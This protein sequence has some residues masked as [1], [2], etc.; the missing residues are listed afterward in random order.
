MRLFSSQPSPLRAV[1]PA[2]LASV[3][4]LLAALP[5]RAQQRP[6]RFYLPSTAI[7]LAPPSFSG[8]LLS[9]IPTTFE[10]PC[11]YGGRGALIFSLVT[12][13]AGMTIDATSGVL[14]WIP[15][16]TAEGTA[17]AVTVGA[18]DG[19][20]SA[21]VSFMVPVAASTA[22]A[23]SV[24]GS[25]VKVTGA[26][27]LQNLK[28]TLPTGASVAPTALGVSRVPAAAAPGL[29]KGV[30]R[31]SEFFRTTPVQAA[32]G[33][34]T[35]A[36]PAA[37]VPSGR[38]PEE[39]RLYLYSDGATNRTGRHWMA[40]WH[41]LN[42]RASGE[43]TIDIAQLGE[44]SF[45]GVEK[46]PPDWSAASEFGLQP[47]VSAIRQS[48]LA[49]DISCAPKYFEN[50][51]TDP[52]QRVCTVTGD[53]ALTVIVKHFKTDWWTPSTDLTELVGW[54]GAAA[55]EFTALGLRFDSTFEVA[56]ERMEEADD[57]GFVSPVEDYKV[58]H[59]T[60]ARL[61]KTLLQGT[62]VHE[63]FHHAQARTT[64]AGE[65]NV[66]SQC[67]KHAWWL[68]EGTARWFEDHLFDD[69]DT[70]RLK[71]DQPLQP[72]LEAGLG[73]YPG[74]DD[75]RPYARF[76]FC[77]MLT[78]RCTGFKLAE[79]LNKEAAEACD[80]LAT[81]ERRMASTS[82][83]CDFYAGF[84]E[85]NTATLASA[86]LLY[87]AATTKEDDITLLDADEQAFSFSTTSDTW[88][89]VVVPSP[90][91]A[92][93]ST[94]A[95]PLGGY[96]PRASASTWLVRAA[97]PLQ[98]GEEAVVWFDSGGKDAWVWIA[99]NESF[100]DLDEGDWLR[101]SERSE[102]IYASGGWAPELFLIAV[103]PST[104]TPFFLK[105][106]AGVRKAAVELPFGYFGEYKDPVC[107]S[108]GDFAMTASG[109]VRGPE[110]TTVAVEAILPRLPKVKIVAPR[111]GDPIVITGMADAF[112]ASS[113]GSTVNPDGTRVEWRY[114]DKVYILDNGTTTESPAFTYTIPADAFDAGRLFAVRYSWTF[115]YYDAEG[116]KTGEQ[117]SFGT[118]AILAFDI[119]RPRS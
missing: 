64:R 7:R 83:G 100:V 53:V 57:L 81:L 92:A 58:L 107:S 86:L 3:L 4:G 27:S 76:A 1:V 61:G 49:L 11:R 51:S 113:S 37:L 50:G 66:L 40:S 117:S 69:L 48:G 85:S 112:P 99:D 74:R 93:P 90:D 29:P 20:A 9:D 105:I 87:A 80:A 6:P 14:T 5:G 31:L 22:L 114:Y 39:L 98:Q 118:K 82:W 103:N 79:V 96:A 84:G 109:K 110:G 46:E 111:T 16:M 104:S 70:Y 36:L 26:G 24:S 91:C 23:V 77:K 89:K 33:G 55:K 35:V 8:E 52:Y 12:G 60:H 106:G 101:T 56:V 30:T 75:K 34:I 63:F 67:G 19:T 2:V 41:N 102:H 73:S 17:V 28:V 18:T 10:V 116:A 25:T 43:I 108:C 21:Q 44:L 47:T 45:V 95:A 72:I 78:S 65:T 68:T 94:C 71:E 88:W 119:H 42:V 38:R 15:P 62:A 32:S 54:F 115:T 13:P 97:G 59:L